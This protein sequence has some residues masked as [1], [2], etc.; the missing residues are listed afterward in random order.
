MNRLRILLDLVSLIVS[1]VC[2]SLAAALAIGGACMGA[3]LSLGFGVIPDYLILTL[4][5]I[6]PAGVLGGGIFLTWKFGRKTTVA[7]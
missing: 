7:E 6:I 1:L 4:W 2:I 5:I 3:I